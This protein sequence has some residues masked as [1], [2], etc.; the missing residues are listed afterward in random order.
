MMRLKYVH[1]DHSYTTN[2]CEFI[3]KLLF[4]IICMFAAKNIINEQKKLAMK[5]ERE[6][7]T[8]CCR[9]TSANFP[10]NLHFFNLTSLY[11]DWYSHC[12]GFLGEQNWA[13]IMKNL[14]CKIYLHEYWSKFTSFKSL[15][16]FECWST[17][18]HYH[19]CR[20]YSN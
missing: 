16:Y 8:C 6:K 5:K 4:V 19:V 17:Q 18:Q 20:V 1:A 13:I 14:W 10:K 12:A 3:Y 9:I 2:E 11:A 7:Q 15:P